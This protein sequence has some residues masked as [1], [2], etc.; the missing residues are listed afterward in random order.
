MENRPGQD[1]G[2]GESDMYRAFKDAAKRSVIFD[3]ILY[4]QQKRE[5]REWDRQSAP[6]PH[7]F[8]QKIVIEYANKYSIP[9]LVDMSRASIYASSRWL[10]GIAEAKTRLQAGAA[11][12]QIL[13][14]RI[15][16]PTKKSAAGLNST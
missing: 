8:K 15:K 12:N 3:T 14:P 11:E 6:T 5:L 2:L 10:D 9:T 13:I 16:F 4:F 7:M 1:S